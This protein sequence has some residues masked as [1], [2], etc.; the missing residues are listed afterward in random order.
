ME[1]SNSNLLTLSAVAEN[2]KEGIDSV[3]YDGGIESGSRL[4]LGKMTNNYSS[5]SSLTNS[6]YGGKGGGMHNGG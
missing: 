3:K 6:A 1:R 5:T 4:L 2:D